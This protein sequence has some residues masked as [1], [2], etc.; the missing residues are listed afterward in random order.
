MYFPDEASPSAMPL[1]IPQ[2]LHIDAERTISI[3]TPKVKNRRYSQC[4]LPFP[5]R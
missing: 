4:M 5:L 3:N 2:S 1:N